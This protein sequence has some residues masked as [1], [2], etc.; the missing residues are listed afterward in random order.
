MAAYRC[1][2]Y[3][4][5]FFNKTIIIL[6]VILRKTLFVYFGL[7]CCKIYLL[8]AVIYTNNIL[9]SYRRHKKEITAEKLSCK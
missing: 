2:Y 4:T 5:K 9:P 3:S 8:L 6:N 7:N 1:L